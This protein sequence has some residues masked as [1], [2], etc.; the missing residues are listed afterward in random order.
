MAVNAER[1]RRDCPHRID[2]IE[3]EDG[4]DG[5]DDRD[6]GATTAQAGDEQDRR[7]QV[8]TDLERQC[9]SWTDENRGAD[10]V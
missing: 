10:K 6:T 4:D 3:R 7:Q 8:E 9:P 1:T 2:P 5:T